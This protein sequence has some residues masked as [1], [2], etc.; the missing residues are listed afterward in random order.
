M[1][2]R[3]V[4]GRSYGWSFGLLIAFVASLSIFGPQVAFCQTATE[5]QETTESDEGEAT[6]AIVVSTAQLEDLVP[7]L[8]YLMRAC[9]QAEMSGMVS[10]VVNQYTQGMDLTKPAG[11]AMTIEASGNPT[12]V[13]MLPVNDIEA[14]FVSIAQFGEPEEIE[15]GLYTLEVG[16]QTVFAYHDE[17]W[18][19]VSSSEDAVTK[20]DSDPEELLGSLAKRYDVG[21]R[22]EVDELPEDLVNMLIGQARSAFESASAQAKSQLKRDIDRAT[23]EAEKAKAIAALSAFEISQQTNEKQLEQMEKVLND[24]DSVVFGLR[25]DPSAKLAALEVATKFLEGTD[26]SEQL[27]NSAKSKTVFGSFTLDKSVFHLRTS[28]QML[29]KQIEESKQILA[30]SWGQLEA[31]LRQQ[32]DA[33][34]W[35]GDLLTEFRSVVEGT[36][37]KGV[38]DLGLSI[39]VEPKPTLV[40]GMQVGD[41]TKVA[42]MAKEFYGKIKNEKNAPTIQFDKGT[43][44]SVTIHTGSIPLPPEADDEAKAIFGSAV[45]FAIGTSKEMIFFCAGENAEA[46]LK[47]SIDKVS[48]PTP[49]GSK[50]PVDALLTLV[51]ILQYAE[52]AQK[53][54]KAEMIIQA[55][56]EGARSAAG[57]DHVRV[58][59]GFIEN[60]AVAEIAFEEGVLKAIGSA[61]KAAQ[62]AQAQ[63]RARQRTR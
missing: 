31:M 52:T 58:S 26:F 37:D 28:D 5:T 18:L 3:F 12:P 56:L 34:D 53:D 43:H 36:L 59:S 14:F 35:V 42:S 29:P 6:P 4:A 38:S 9:N 47:S 44:K 62:G 24:T 57:K 39:A 48:A 7:H 33:P 51:P 32:K 20:F 8:S 27:T 50:G 11:V 41:G 25:I 30:S 60:G 61:A 19:Y 54:P 55:M 45:Q 49:V 10:L 2:S 22:I 16:P 15:E 21:V 46:T 17:D 1:L 63:P 23:D 13:V 40:M